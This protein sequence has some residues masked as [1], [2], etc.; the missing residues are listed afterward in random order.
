MVGL[1]VS[2]LFCACSVR[3]DSILGKYRLNNAG[4]NEITLDVRSDHTFLQRVRIAGKEEDVVTGVWGLNQMPLAKNRVSSGTANYDPHAAGTIYLSNAYSFR[5]CPS[6][7]ANRY[8]SIALPIER[9]WRLVILVEVPDHGVGYEKQ[10]ASRRE[11]LMPQEYRGENP[12]A[13][14]SNHVAEPIGHVER[15]SHGGR[16]LNYNRRPQ[17]DWHQGSLLTPMLL[18][19]TILRVA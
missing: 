18:R 10:S 13:S 6:C 8:D 12:V 19:D 14:I 1:A 15:L 11:S 4:T 2:V 17:R 7:E 9:L 16:W 5:N 3:E